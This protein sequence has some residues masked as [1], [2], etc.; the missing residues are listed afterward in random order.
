MKSIAKE[1]YEEKTNDEIIK[2]QEIESIESEI[3]TVS[4]LDGNDYQIS[5]YFIPLLI[6][7]L[8]TRYEGVLIS[9]N[10]IYSYDDEKASALKMELED[11]AF[12]S[13][14]KITTINSK[15]CENST[16]NSSKYVF[17]FDNL[18]LLTPE[19]EFPENSL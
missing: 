17:S 6:N 16:L 2:K 5:Y 19:T 8:E 12:K 9:V 14:I 10:I 3:L 11:C 1:N 4:V 13:L 15:Q 7:L 18:D